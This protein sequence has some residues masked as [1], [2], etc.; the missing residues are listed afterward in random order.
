MRGIQPI[1][2]TGEE[3]VVSTEGIAIGGDPQIARLVEVPTPTNQ[4]AA[5]PS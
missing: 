5:D 4:K 3:T 1:P 2:R